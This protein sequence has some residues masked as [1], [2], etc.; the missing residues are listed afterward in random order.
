MGPK[1]EPKMG[2]VVNLLYLGPKMWQ[3]LCAVVR[4]AILGS[5]K[6]VKKGVIINIVYLGP[7]NGAVVN[8]V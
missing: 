4:P 8:L 3:K 7:K 2:A 1:N 6:R 5:K